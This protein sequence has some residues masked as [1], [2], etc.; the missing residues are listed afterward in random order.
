[1]EFL[2]D[3]FNHE[4][5]VNYTKNNMVYTFDSIQEVKKWEKEQA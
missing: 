2:A 3:I 4:F 5:R 1:M